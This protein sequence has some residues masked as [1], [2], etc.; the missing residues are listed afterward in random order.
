M[1]NRLATKVDIIGFVI[2]TLM[3]DSV[4]TKMKLIILTRSGPKNVASLSWRDLISSSW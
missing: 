1:V 3:V 2:V 4:T